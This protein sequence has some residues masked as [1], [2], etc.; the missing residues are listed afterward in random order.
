MIRTIVCL[1]FALSLPASALAQDKPSTAGPGV[2]PWSEPMAMPGLERQRRVQVYLPPGYA[3]SGKRYPV[4]Y[5]H[6]GLN[7]FDDRSSFVGEWGVDESL[8]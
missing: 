1:L 5:L 7:V 6:D 4:L 2:Q 3:D 8:D